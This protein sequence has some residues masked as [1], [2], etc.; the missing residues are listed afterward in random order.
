MSERILVRGEFGGWFTAG[1]VV[2]PL[3]TV[4]G[5]IVYA[6]QPIGTQWITT[7]GLIWM[8]TFE[9][10]ATLRRMNRLWIE[11]LPDG[12]MLIDRKQEVEHEDDDVQS[13]ALSQKKSFS[14]GDADG[15]VRTARLWLQ[16]E[17]RPVFMKNRF[18]AG[19][20]DPLAG[21]FDR[22]ANKLIEQR[23]EALGSGHSISGDGWRL[24]DRELHFQRGSGEESL[25][26]EEVQAIDFF[27]GK[28]SVWRKGLDEPYVRFS[29]DGRDA[30]MLPR[31]MSS[32]IKP[33]ESDNSG[34]GRILFQ[35]RSS[36]LTVGFLAASGLVAIAFGGT[37]LALE[38]IDTFGFVFILLLT[39]AFWLW[40]WSSSKS[41][42]RCHERGVYQAKM[43][44]EKQLK[45]QDVAEFTYRATRHYHNGAYTGTI[46]SLKFQ[47]AAG[48][49]KAI[50]Y[51]A[52]VRNEDADLDSLRDFI[53]RVIA[54]RMANELAAGNVTPWM[55]NIR[56]RP[57]GL[58]YNASGF[59]RTKKETTLMPHADYGGW[60]V[61][62]GTFLLFARGNSKAVLKA[63]T[64][65]PNFFPGFYLLQ[66]IYHQQAAEG[67]APVFDAAE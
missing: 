1:R 12:F 9:S 6:F 56:F 11:V 8:I 4:I 53:S 58:E 65:E 35:R 16:S 25:R 36:K 22:L 34:L 41:A 10:I 7:L 42:F 23:E 37:M 63:Q 66:L 32:R 14:N 55:S 3:V 54:A 52:T 30:W 21:F 24:T 27:E 51:G 62:G 31:L 43:F 19:K 44:G 2:G 29:D 5:F 40:A 61:Q 49:G 28:M 60:N 59:L 38:A 67:P 50:S 46:L 39:V 18:K 20:T 26:M 57:D 17:S 45:Y 48:A 15:F 13:L 47:P 64:S 33:D